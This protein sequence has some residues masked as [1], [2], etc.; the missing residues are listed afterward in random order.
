MVDQIASA[1]RRRVLIVDNDHSF[2]DVLAGDLKTYSCEVDTARTPAEAIARVASAAPD[3]VVLD[4]YLPGGAALDLLRLWKAQLPGLVVILVSDNASLS[5]VVDALKEGAHKFFTKPIAAA[6]LLDEFE[7]RK[8][9]QHPSVSSL[10]AARHQ[11]GAAA[12][13]AEGI[14]RFFAI[15]PG[16]LSVAGFDGYFKMLNPAWEKALG[17]S[18]AELCAMPFLELVHPEDRVKATDEA[19]ELR[20]SETVFRFKNRYRCKDGTY[21][22][23]EWL[24]TPSPAHHL[25]YSSARDVT[26]SV[27]MEQGLRDSYHRLMR[28]VTKRDVMLRTCSDTNATLAQ[29]NNVL[30]G[31][32]DTLVELGRFKDEIAAMI[33][34][35]LRNPLSVI[36]A[37]YDYL[38][39]GFEGGADC[40][41][42]LQASRT[43]GQRMLRLL[44]NLV[45]VARFEEGTLSV[46]ASEISVVGLLESVAE[47]RR[48]LAESRNI[49]IVVTPSPELMLT[50]DADLLTRTIENIFDN[51]LR[52]TPRGGIVKV[53]LREV[54]P[55]VEIRIGNSGEAIPVEARHTIFDKYEQLG[56]NIR[57]MNL[58]LGLY[59]CRLAVEAQGGEI[60]VEEH[61]RLPA[62][63]AIRMPRVAAN[64]PPPVSAVSGA[65][66]ERVSDHGAR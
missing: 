21:R 64:A 6:A 19:L 4:L 11:L 25:I 58:G 66:R 28:V 63:F 15:S 46:S 65:P 24:A 62:V 41:E 22:W 9:E 57:R 38:L 29:E 31:K 45:D 55:N 36:V 32:N 47:Q 33:V 51:A 42:A 23:L 18:V 10:V 52:H 34:H 39:E 2:G 59:F 37:N 56:S 49:S 13:N 50:V 48:V 26:K 16:L 61:E 44:A 3:M 20:G 43:A 17:Y 1:R 7:R 27:R 35:D 8:D 40:L 14:D 53:E 12:L 30:V 54:G 5:V 60:W